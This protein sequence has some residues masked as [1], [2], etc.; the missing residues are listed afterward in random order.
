M[1]TSNQPIKIK[2]SDFAV[3]DERSHYVN[4]SRLY[5]AYFEDIPNTIII[6][7]VNHVPT[8]KWIENS[9]ADQILKTHSRQ[10][11]INTSRKRR[12]LEYTC[13]N[14]ILKDKILIKIERFGDIAIL[15]A[16]DSAE[17]AK[18]FAHEIKKFRHKD[19]AQLTTLIENSNG[20]KLISLRCK[21]PNLSLPI[22]YTDDLNDLHINIIK[23]LKKKNNS[24]LFLFHGTP[25]TGKSTYLRY[26]M[27]Y[28]NKRV[29]FLPPK[30]AGNLDS[31]NL[32]NIL[33]EEP[34]SILVIED[35][36]NLLTSREKGNESSISMLLNLTD[37][38]L[39]ESLGIQVI[40]TFNSSLVNIDKALL[41]KGRLKTLYEFKPLSILKSLALL[42]KLGVT[43]KTV[44]EP[45]TLAD[46]YNIR[47]QHFEFAKPHRK[48]GFGVGVKI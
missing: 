20:L 34:N 25:G 46:I 11:C 14:Y 44:N 7:N 15:Y 3:F 48:I 1:K 8:I 38:L 45:M 37:G 22:N 5:F 26:L 39:G 23:D 10:Q 9:L 42:K 13:I 40:C 31:P 29:I 4:C 2:V 16:K 19:S 32:V 30:I 21:K 36:E 33:V 6:S 47:E 17:K 12:K 28:T 41:R 35:A 27:H 43:D 24:G 18:I